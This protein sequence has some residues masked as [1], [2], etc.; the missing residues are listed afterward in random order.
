[1]PAQES[2]SFLDDV[3]KSFDKAAKF[4]NWDLGILQQIKACNSIYR[5]RF[6]IKR[7]NG[8]IEVIEAVAHFQ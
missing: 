8:S 2:Y 1:M 3:N 4:T 6:P 5:M 7:D